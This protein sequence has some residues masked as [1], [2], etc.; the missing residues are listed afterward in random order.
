M[1]SFDAGRIPNFYI[2]P[3]EIISFLRKTLHMVNPSSILY[4]HK[5]G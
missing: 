4:D 5:N 3:E 1:L 2:C